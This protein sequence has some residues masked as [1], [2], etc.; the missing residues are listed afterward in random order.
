VASGAITDAVTFPQ[1]SH[2]GPLLGPYPTVIV[3]PTSGHVYLARL[4]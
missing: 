1:S 2:L 3:F 4:G